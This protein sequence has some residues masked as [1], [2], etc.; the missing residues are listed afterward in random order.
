ML[1]WIAFKLVEHLRLRPNQQRVLP[2]QDPRQED[3][4]ET[5]KDD[6]KEERETRPL[7][8]RRRQTKDSSYDQQQ[9]T[10]TEMDEIAQ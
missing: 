10:F 3:L 1:M 7:K 9:L 5:V 6:L 8:N 4:K 2:D